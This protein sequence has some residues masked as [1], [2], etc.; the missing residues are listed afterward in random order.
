MRTT[1]STPKHQLN[2]VPLSSLEQLFDQVPDIAFFV[3]DADGRYVAINQSLAARHGLASKQEAIGKRPSDICKGDFGKSP[4]EQDYRVLRSGAPMIDHLEMQWEMPGRP[5]WCITTKLPPK[6]ASGKTIGIVGFSKDVRS[7]VEPSVVPGSF[8]RALEIFERDLPSEASP[9]WLAKLA[10]MPTHRFSRTMKLIFGITPTQYI[11]KSR[12]GKASNLL[13]QTNHT[14]SEI[15]QHCGYFDHS[16][17]SR[18]FK[19]ATGSTPI[20]FRRQWK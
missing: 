11:A 9:S 1:E 4:A 16:A 3:K 19:K 12:L 15:A 10:K 13:L 2:S 6:D 17:F 5:V 8:A 20:S 14:I 18:A 7:A